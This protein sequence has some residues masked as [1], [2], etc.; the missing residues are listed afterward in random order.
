MA[1]TV[2]LSL[3]SYVSNNAD[4]I[5]TGTTGADTT[6]KPVGSRD[7]LGFSMD[8]PVYNSIQELFDRSD[9]VVVASFK[10]EQ[11]DVLAYSEHILR[12]KNEEENFEGL[13]V[14]IE[15]YVTKIVLN[16]SEV[17]KGETAGSSIILSQMGQYKSNDY[18]TKLKPNTKYLLFLSERNYDKEFNETRAQEYNDF[19]GG[20]KILYQLSNAEVSIFEISEDD[21]LHSYVDYGFATTYDGKKLGYLVNEF[22]NIAR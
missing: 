11:K 1:L 19:F 13:D 14:L 17:V 15:R 2:H 4:A 8:L 10:D 3:L 16:V 7:T 12:P 18:E 9:L 22:R 5:G 20:D 21:T 6:K